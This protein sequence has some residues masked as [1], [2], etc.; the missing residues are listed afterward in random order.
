MTLIKKKVE[1]LFE[2]IRKKI[3][4]LL[5]IL[6]IKV[7]KPEETGE[8][9]YEDLTPNNNVD[10][11]GKYSEAIS[12]GLKN[13]NVKN[14][15][16]TG[17]YGSGK[18]SLL[19]TFQR[20]Q[21]FKY[22]FLNISLAT[23]H[24]AQPDIESELEKNILQQMIYRVH[25][26]TIPFSRFKRI[27][28]IKPKNIYMQI[29]LFIA[30]TII[31]VYLLRP[32]LLKSIYN[33]T[34]VARSLNNNDTLETSITA[35][36]VLIFLIYLLFIFRGLFRYIKSNIRVNKVTIANTTVESDINQQSESVFDKYLDEILYFFE[37]SKFNV[38][39]FEDLD[40]FENI[41]IFEKLRELNELINNSKQVN[42]RVV[43][44][45]AVK[46][47][48]FGKEDTTELTKNR[49]K[50]FDF[51][52]PVIPIMNASNS[53]DILIDKVEKSPFKGKIDQ[54]FV[55][56]VTIYIDD[57]RV[58]KNI[59]NEFLVYQ[60]NL[61]TIDLDINKLLAMIIYK[62]IYP[63]DFSRLQYNDG[64][65][66]QVFRNKKNLIENNVKLVDNSIKNLENI[67][68]RTESEP[69]NS[70][71]E[72]RSVYGNELKKRLD[73]SQYQNYIKIDGTEYN[74]NSL[75]FDSFFDRLKNANEVTYT[76][77]G[78]YHQTATVNDIATIFGTKTNYFEREDAVRIIEHNELQEAKKELSSLRIERQEISGYSLQTIISKSNLKEIFTEEIYEK[79]LLVYLLRNGYIDEMYSHYVTYFYPASLSLSDI[80]FVFS[81]KNHER[82]EFDY[83]IK[84][85]EKIINKLASSE[86]RQVEVLNYNLLNYIIDLDEYKSL[87]DKM[88]EQL[89]DGS[90]T[91]IEF[92]HGF[93]DI[94][95]NK[96]KFIKSISKWDEFWSYII[97]KSNYTNEEKDAY[98][99]DILTYAD[100]QDIVLMD[101]NSDVT[102]LI[103]KYPHILNRI[104][105]KEKIKELLLQIPVAIEKVESLFESESLYS[106]V[107]E[108]NLYE[109]NKDNL[110]N[111]LGEVDH[112]TYAA[113]KNSNKQCVID[114]VDDNIMVFMEKVLLDG[115]IQEEPEESL[116]YLLNWDK[117]N[118][119]AKVTAIASDINIIS[120]INKINK[121]LWSEVIGKNKVIASW[122]NVI[123]SFIEFDNELTDPLVSFINHPTNRTNL[124][125][126]KIEDLE[127]FENDTL[128]K[129][130]D[131][132]IK[133]EYITDETFEI[134]ASSILSWDFYPTEGLS[135]RRVNAMIDYGVLG[136]TPENFNSLKSNFNKLHIKLVTK[137]IEVLTSNQPDFSLDNRDIR[138]L[139]NNADISDTHKKRLIIQLDLTVL[140]NSNDDTLIEIIDYIFDHNLR[141]S[142]ELLSILLASKI[143]LRTKIRL[144]TIQ[145]E[146]ME[147][148]SITKL[149][150][151]LDEPYSKIAENKK[152][153]KIRNDE[154]NKAFIVALDTRNYISSFTEVGVELRVNTRA[155]M[156]NV[157]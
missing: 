12:W 21:K 26:K 20:N 62:N 33:K 8:D 6:L 27:K 69:L 2:K 102:S 125:L 73:A 47:D 132:I 32:D 153:I 61:I 89:I 70:V 112:V 148:E 86:F 24:T 87:Y 152:R 141:I 155:K 149:L 144:F 145:T 138:R 4:N 119:N 51:I 16:I 54:Q 13:E 88:M 48:I 55:E 59:F 15:A 120:D 122:Q 101:K 50:F 53:G 142:E 74:Y 84:N 127:D 38:I 146:H 67:I 78:K 64:L 118:Q 79:K 121:G 7:S 92:I 44:I 63:I 93:K 104:P 139:L 52:I 106:Y 95:L 151:L 117:I 75:Q 80:K 143:S 5:Q 35:F 116:L 130:S 136:V 46:D 19:H 99:V 156:D 68:K 30:F 3:E 97:T 154:I 37:A 140:S 29:A 57:M 133:C 58:L 157:N 56:D 25:N 131:E 105:N 107:L 49:T 36:L 11:H 77:D 83:E 39:I 91:S 28:H 10:K 41:D 60:K 43:F 23:F 108:H 128:E 66:Y 137:D 17:P 14:I 147:I 40:R 150:L 126:F 34:L 111:I 113:I 82:L 100:V 115:N 42:R 103:S 114:Y 65:V 81:I 90:S 109:I 98:L 22:Q 72:L 134:I 85:V 18:S 110:A 71:Q 129:I 76:L 45:Y 96:A 123:T 94:A 31:G 124:A 135:G 1:V 9:L